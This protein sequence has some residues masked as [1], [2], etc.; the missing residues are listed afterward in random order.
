MAKD[1]REEIRSQFPEII[2]IQK[3]DNMGFSHVKDV[4]EI[5]QNGGADDIVL[6]FAYDPRDSDLKERIR[7]FVQSIRPKAQRVIFY[8]WNSPL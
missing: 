5:D 4:D 6:Y 3:G 1:L 8:Y 7:A 2:V